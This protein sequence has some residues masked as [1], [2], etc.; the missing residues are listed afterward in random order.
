MAGYAVPA[1]LRAPQ[2]LLKPLDQLLTLQ[3]GEAVDPEQ[4]VE[5]IDFMLASDG[6]QAI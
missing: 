6:A 3:A 4:A 2:Q 5:L 1:R